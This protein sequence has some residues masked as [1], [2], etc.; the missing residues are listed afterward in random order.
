VGNAG[1]A[2]DGGTDGRG[3][4]KLESTLDHIDLTKEEKERRMLT[5]AKK[6]NEPRRLYSAGEDKTTATET[7]EKKRK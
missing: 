5:N 3:L 1:G 7:C 6:K 4:S 2:S